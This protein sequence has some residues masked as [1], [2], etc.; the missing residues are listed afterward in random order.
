MWTQ[1]PY[2]NSQSIAITTSGANYAAGDCV[3][4]LISLVNVNESFGRRVSLRSIQINDKGGIAPSLNI[5]FFKSQPAGTF[6]DNSAVVWAAGDSAL[7]VGQVSVLNANYLTDISQ[8]AINLSG[9]TE[10]MPV[11]DRTLYMVIVSQS[12]Y[13]LAASTL[14]AQIELDQE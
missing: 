13:T 7:K 8:S 14:T 3:G 2:S 6:T 11:A 4:G 9:L 1:A 12:T 10:K 5:Y